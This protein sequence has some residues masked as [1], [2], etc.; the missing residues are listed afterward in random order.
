MAGPHRNHIESRSSREPA[1]QFLSDSHDHKP[2][3][4]GA[5]EPD[6]FTGVSFSVEETLLGLNV[7]TAKVRALKLSHTTRNVGAMKLGAEDVAKVAGQ[8]KAL[9]DH[10]AGVCV[11]HQARRP[12]V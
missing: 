10:L 12:R 2:D 4:P 11:R 1:R 8:I 9:N 6:F 3:A 5:E 7:L